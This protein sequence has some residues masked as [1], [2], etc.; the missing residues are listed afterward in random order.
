[1]K[2]GSHDLFLGEI[3]AVH[4]DQDVLD[5]KGRI[6]YAKAKPFVYNQCE[7]WSLGKKIEVS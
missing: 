5:E 2:L 1:V 3:V 7:Y 6:D 4:V